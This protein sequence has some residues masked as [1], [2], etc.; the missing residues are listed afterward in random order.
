MFALRADFV[1]ANRD[2]VAQPRWKD[3]ADGYFSDKYPIIV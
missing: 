2:K 1:G 3:A